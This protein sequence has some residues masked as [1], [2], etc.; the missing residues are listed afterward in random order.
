MSTSVTQFG[1]TW[2]WV[3]DLTVGQ[4]ANGDYYVVAPSG[5]T[6][7]E[8]LP[9]SAVD[10]GRTKNGSMVNPTAGNSASQGF[11]SSAGGFSS[12]L[13]AALPGGSALSVGNPLVVAAGSSI[14]SCES[15]A[16]PPT[17]SNISKLLNGAVLTVVA[18]AP[19]ANSFRPPYCGTDKTHNWNV[20]DLDYSILSSLSQVGS[21]T[22][23]LATVEGYFER[24]WFEVR[25]NYEGR[26][27]HP[28]N[29]QPDYG[30]D[31][32][33]RVG[34]A[35]LSL[36]LNYSNAEKE[37][38]MVRLVQYGLDIYGAA[39]SGGT[40]GADGGHNVGRKS[41]LLLAGLTFNDAN[42]L[43]YGDAAQNFIFQEDR[44]TFYVSAATMDVTPLTSD[45]RA[46][47]PYGGGASATYTSPYTATV[48]ISNATPA[49]VSWTAHGL[50]K[51]V[52]IYFT[53]TG[54][55]PSP[56]T[57]NTIYWISDTGFSTD[58][59]QICAT[60]R[61][62]GG[63]Q[64]ASINTTNAGSGVHTAN[65][66]MLGVAEWGEK[67]NTT[68]TRDGANW[69][70]Y[71]REINTKPGVGL[72]LAAHLT[73]GAVAAWNWAAYFDYIDRAKDDAGSTNN[74]GHRQ[75]QRKHRQ[76]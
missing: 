29:N 65:Y 68:P 70:A 33:E 52:P 10:S 69:T 63:S 73:T 72:A 75:R 59:F 49:V 35:Y 47:A 55:L 11:D 25:T 43:A 76:P 64:A 26:Y 51:Q 34:N 56:L 4:Y 54:S 22:P 62:N 61:L 45:G 15:V 71:Y 31:M 28:Y 9:A 12:A 50:L 18:A 7:T 16:S 1:I 46:R 14:V 74:S 20:S 27:L 38:L 44:Q 2:T 40:W 67:H 19:P 8:I 6:I 5:I 23:A 36:H 66:A 39:V 58:S 21:S 17:G 57:P 42:I 53:T 41:A 13:N 3:E 37:T 32:A 48:T 30:R 60:G 24:P